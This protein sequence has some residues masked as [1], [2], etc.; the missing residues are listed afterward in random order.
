LLHEVIIRNIGF[1]RDYPCFVYGGFLQTPDTWDV[2]LMV[3]TE[4]MPEVGDHCV[5]LCNSAH[6][7]GQL[8]DI[9]IITSE[10]FEKHREQTEWFNKTGDFI[11]NNT[12]WFKPHGKEIYKN[13]VDISSDTEY[14]FISENLWQIKRSK[15]LPEKI[16]Q[17]GRIAEAIPFV[18][19]INK[20]RNNRRRK[21]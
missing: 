14:A 7:V 9:S 15:G 11:P 18:P 19:L 1:F 16:Y 17:R 3:V 20:I 8:L 4:I 13:G 12:R 2:D 5:G 6:R 21:V 10:T